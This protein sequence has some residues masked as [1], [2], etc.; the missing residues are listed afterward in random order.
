M[1]TPRNLMAPS[2]LALTP[3]AANGAFA[4]GFSCYQKKWGGLLDSED[5]N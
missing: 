4:N 2:P 3:T 5:K 1:G